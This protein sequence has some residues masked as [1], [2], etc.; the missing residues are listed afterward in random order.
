[1]PK[2]IMALANSILVNPVK[3]EVERVS[4]AAN[5]VK[6]NIYFVGKSDKKHLLVYLLKNPKIVSVLVFTRTKH[7]ANKVV[8]DLEKA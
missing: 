4:L 1:M 2:E 6:Q 5:T 8:K 3:V 7:G